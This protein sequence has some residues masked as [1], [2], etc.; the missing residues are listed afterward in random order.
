M[1]T[2]TSKVNSAGQPVS[3]SPTGRRFFGLNALAAWVGLATAF[4]LSLLG[5]YPNT[6]LDPTLLGFNADGVDGVI[7]RVSDSLSY[8]THWSNLV[9]AI[10]MTMLWRNSNRTSKLF[11]VLRLDALIMITVTGLVYALILAPVDKVQGWQYVSNTLEHYVTPLLTIAVFIFFGPRKQVHLA[12]IPLALIL[13][14]TWVA[15]A[16][17]RGS[18]IGAYPY[19]FINVATWGYGTVAINLIGIVIIGAGL[20]A[21]YCGIES[22]MTKHV[23]RK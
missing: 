7:G 6:N 23:T 5:T 13:P 15:V 9:V 3:V 19:G 2:Q 16:L 4:V 20:G 11:S 12:L 10:V 18:I 8:F 14:L 1:S 17:I 21:L 22:W